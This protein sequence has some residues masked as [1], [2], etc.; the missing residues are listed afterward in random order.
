MCLSKAT[1]TTQRFSLAPNRR[2]RPQ[3]SR[4][5][6]ELE[7]SAPS[8]GTTP[9]KA[10]SHEKTMIAFLSTAMHFLTGILLRVIG[11][12]AISSHVLGG[13]FEA[14]RPNIIFM[15]VSSHIQIF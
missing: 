8:H 7:T 5:P 6:P 14:N 10:E 4:P 13:I 9:F 3:I 2:S 12:P 1:C 15:G 11:S